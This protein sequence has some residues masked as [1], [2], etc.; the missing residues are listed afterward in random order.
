[1]LL[2]LHSGSFLSPIVHWGGEHFLKKFARLK[3]T[4]FHIRVGEPFY[5]NMNG[6]H[7]TRK[8]CQKI[9]DEMMVRL[10]ELLLPKYREEYEKVTE[11]EEV[12]TKAGK[13]A[14]VDLA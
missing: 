12:F 5:L 10:A 6:V 1:M 13:M 14:K 11:Y 3:R 7:V 8:I 4:E 2:T 9:V